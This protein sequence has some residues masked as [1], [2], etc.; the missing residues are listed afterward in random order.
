MYL[1]VVKS[2]NKCSFSF[3][4]CCSYNM[5]VPHQCTGPVR[6]QYESLRGELAFTT[7][8]RSRIINVDPTKGTAQ[9]CSKFALHD[10]L[11]LLKDLYE[12]GKL[13]FFANTGVINT[14]EMDKFNYNDV[15]RSQ[16]FAHNTMQH[17]IKRVDPYNDIPGTGVLG[18]LAD[19]DEGRN[20]DHGCHDGDRSGS[21]CA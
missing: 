15:T 8:E 2:N 4:R 13:L 16:L 11:K 10:E 5:L 20:Q 1:P 9:P 6:A 17:E 7:A 12:E 19:G 18:R 14:A 3:N 21:E